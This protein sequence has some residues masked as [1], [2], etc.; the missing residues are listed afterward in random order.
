MILRQKYF[1]MEII[2]ICQAVTWSGDVQNSV[3]FSFKKYAGLV[4][5]IKPPIIKSVWVISGVLLYCVDIF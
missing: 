4:E 2:F 3:D 5:Q 1:I